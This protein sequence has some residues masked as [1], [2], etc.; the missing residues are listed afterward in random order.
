[1]NELK[2]EMTIANRFPAALSPPSMAGTGASGGR[3]IFIFSFVFLSVSSVSAVNLS[4][5]VDLRVLCG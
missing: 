5:F 3:S 4:S 1:M 2:R